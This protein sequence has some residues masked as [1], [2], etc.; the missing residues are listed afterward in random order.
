MQNIDL[1]ESEGGNLHLDGSPVADRE[2]P[3]D[4]CLHPHNTHHCKGASLGGPKNQ[5]ELASH[6]RAHRRKATAAMPSQNSQTSTRVRLESI[7]TRG[8]SNLPVS[9]G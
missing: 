6:P 2:L 8:D 5:A 3:L 9:K 7:A 1:S 4:S